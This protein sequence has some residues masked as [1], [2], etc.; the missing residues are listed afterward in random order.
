MHSIDILMDGSRVGSFPFGSFFPAGTLTPSLSVGGIDPVLEAIVLPG[1]T[2][3]GFKGC[4]DSLHVLGQPVDFS[5]SKKAE[6]VNFKFRNESQTV[7]AFHFDGEGYARYGMLCACMCII[8]ELIDGRCVEL[9]KLLTHR[10]WK[11]CT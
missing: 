7:D 3:E 11:I 5:K 10:C 8:I 6:Q 1:V 9:C 2:T 4:I